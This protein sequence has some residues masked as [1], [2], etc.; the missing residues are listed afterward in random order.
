MTEPTPSRTSL[1]KVWDCVA[2][3]SFALLLF[4][5][6][7]F[8]A[9]W[10]A[11][12]W[13]IVP[14]I[15]EFRPQ[16][17]AAATRLLGMPV[18][19]ESI[20][21]HSNNLL[22]AFEMGNVRLLD[23]RGRDAL[24]LP[25]VLVS[26][27]PRSAWRLKFDQI[28]VDSPVL[29]VRRTGDGRIWVAGLDLARGG[30]GAD[31]VLDRIFSQPEFVIRHG[32]V[33]WADELRAVA[34]LSLRDVDVVLRNR[35]RTHEFRFDAT[36]P[37]D[38]GDR[39]RV[40]ARFEQPLLSIGNGRWREWIGQ[41]Y[42]D[43]ARVDVAQLKQYA[44]V[45]VDIGQGRG[46]VRAWLDVQRGRVVGATADV[47]LGDVAVRVDP[48]LE[49]LQMASLSG[50]LSGKFLPGSLEFAT[51]GLAFSMADGMQWPGGNL[52][53]KQ[54]FAGAGGPATGELA[55]D[56]LDL[57]ALAQIAGRLPLGT[58]LHQALVRHEPSGLVERI[59]VHWQ[60]TVDAPV[61]YVAEGRV[62]RLAVQSFP[63]D[64]GAAPGT[65]ASVGMP[66]IRGATVDFSMTEVG[67]TATLAMLDGSIDLPGVF[68]EPVVRM[69]RL[70]SDVAW[71]T[72]HDR[73][74]VRLARLRFS[75]PD[76]DGELQLHWQTSDPARSRGKSRYPGVLDLQGSLSRAVGARVHR[77]LPLAVEPQARNY[78]RDAVLR[79]AGTEVRF[80]VKGDLHDLPFS[81]PK[82]GEFLIS[83][84]ISD[85]ALAYVPASIMPAAA[86]PWPALSQLSGELVIDRQSL[87]V[88]GARA[89]I[90]A[91]PGLQITKADAVIADL[92]H[93]S[94]VAVNLESRGPL[95]DM[96][97]F[98]NGSP[99]AAL[100][101]QWLARAT[102]TGNADLRLKLVVPLSDPERTTVQGS[103]ALQGNDIQLTPDIPRLA[104]ARG[105]IDFSE[106]GFNANAV[107]TRVLGGETRIDGGTVAPAA[108]GAAAARS[109][110]TMAFRLQ[111]VVSAEALRQMR[112]LGFVARLAQRA[113]GS[114]AYTAT[115]GLRA[116][117]PEFSVSSSL[118]GLA[119]N[120][121]APLG[122][123]AESVLPLRLE[124]ALV[125]ESLAT[126]GGPA[127]RLQDQLVLDLA[128][129]GS[130]QYVRDL[131]SGEPRVLR[132]TIAIGL[133]ADEAAPLPRDGVVAH[134]RLGDLDLDVWEKLLAQLTAAGP[135]ASDPVAAP[136]DAGAPMQVAP[137]YW[138]TTV[139]LRV[140]SLT[141]GGHTLHNLV[142]GGSRDG[143]T[144][145]A[146]LDA[147]ELNGYVEYRQPTGAGAGR[148]FA[149]LA[150]LTLAQSSAS[151]V[152][153][154]LNEQPASIPALDIVVDELELRG[155]KLGRV[156]IEAINRVVADRGAGAREWRLNKFD[157]IAPE[158]V[159]RATGNWAELNAQ[160]AL[161]PEAPIGSARQTGSRR[162]VMKFRLEIG[163]AGDL[164]ARLGM[165][166]VVRRGKG[167]M[168]GQ[169]AWAG[170]PLSLDYASLAGAF[171]VNVE[172]G[173]FLK[174][175]PGLAKLL[176][177]L[178]LQSLPR[179][180]VL[181]FRDV[182]SE[183]F[184]FDFFR[185]DVKIDEGIAR[186]GNL[187][188]KGV[189]AAVLMEGQADLFRETQDIRV[190]VV[191][192]INA[193]TASLIAAA[194]NPAIGLGSFLA[195]FVLRRP[196][197]DAATQE[198]HID[199]SWLDPR[200][201][202]IERK[203]APVSSPGQNSG[204]PD[205][206]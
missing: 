110:Q 129:I 126:A 108:S 63:D 54:Q 46:A 89:G 51:R 152:E 67:G 1:L 88:K 53:L 38:W 3:W 93:A 117:I 2:R 41:V 106:S 150:R 189:N 154:L 95:A 72:D 91:L 184:A 131:S 81:N 68:E 200:I 125:R 168:E 24:R 78:V 162:T 137:A 166:D 49:P 29:T 33:V 156:E 5:W 142:V 199:G 113:S 176:G 60:G 85:A 14:R 165:G 183:G 79:G 146:N 141:A 203:A 132:G 121:P 86:R 164:L 52:T 143:Q 50:R 195:Q 30:T 204:S 57:A 144:W 87:M 170:S 77:Y 98:V 105:A 194:I 90:A 103:L 128:R 62:V 130:L 112:E 20:A 17:E 177:V 8:A 172:N 175:E 182:F 48:R 23:D 9:S 138:P 133:G 169:V 124:S 123:N 34:P 64:T 134:V 74:Q 92:M 107:L 42:A 71:Q 173:Q 149:R 158:A 196:L 109:A 47:A 13:L 28:H 181:D 16:L 201:Q 120:L 45:G 18:R 35:F 157:V 44:D 102:A 55:A 139:A 96:L 185:G 11:L 116:G 205:S 174:A 32:S 180:L 191:P 206:K 27:S 163:N 101:D 171:S 198:F 186:S 73:V 99:V 115:L 69:D 15:G 83:A 187:Q 160:A 140:R 136:R 4:A 155:K 188:M 178:S 43:F 26:L 100:T 10:G 84:R 19:I 148:M 21:A 25:R 82:Q 179:R 58:A 76:A 97:G 39:F 151:E 12:H 66:G 147:T 167:T 31:D 70:S 190:V 114:A 75:N 145:R 80:K 118:A 7:L 37:P 197:I 65:A 22:P 104:R 127:P 56:R 161:A 122:K 119:V 94:T 192:E 135:A 61:K 40:S 59:K 111:G 159:F 202:R 6:V 36:P 153:S 193:G